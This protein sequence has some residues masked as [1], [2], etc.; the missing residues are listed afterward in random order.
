MSQQTDRT[1]SSSDSEGDEN[2]SE[3]SPVPATFYPDEENFS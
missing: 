1:G 2:P 3:D